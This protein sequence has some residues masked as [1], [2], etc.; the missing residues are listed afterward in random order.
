M[1]A[2]ADDPWTDHAQGPQSPF[3]ADLAGHLRRHH[4]HVGRVDPVRHV[5]PALPALTGGDGDLAAGR[6]ELEHQG[7]VAVVRPARRRPRGVGGVRD[8]ARGQ[9]TRG[10][11][12]VEHPAA[13]PLVG[14][15]PVDVLR[16]PV[17]PV[18]HLGQVEAE[19]RHRT[20]RRDHRLAHH[21][22]RPV[23]EYRAV[24]LERLPQVVGRVRR[25]HPAP[26]H[27]VGAG[28]HRV[29][30]VQ[31]QERQAVEDRHQ[32]VGPPGVEQLGPDRDPARLLAGEPAHAVSGSRGSR[33]PG[34]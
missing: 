27:E 6:E 5:P 16:V 13:E 19:V 20:Y 29:R 26:G 34:G 17:R 7:D 9:R 10:P 30:G 8:V 24:P 33:A 2:V 18:G 21:L 22:A 32:V 15:E 28:R 23:L 11:Q 25:T 14:G 4:G 12:L 31:L 1:P 3:V